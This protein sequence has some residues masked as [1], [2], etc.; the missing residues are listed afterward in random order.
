M[1]KYARF[2]YEKKIVDNTPEAVAESDEKLQVYIHN[3][4][5]Q[6]TLRYRTYII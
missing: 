1:V 2:V 3:T 4:T 5:W 6:V